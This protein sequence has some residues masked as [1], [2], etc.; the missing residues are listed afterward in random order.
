MKIKSIKKIRLD[1]PKQ[2]YDISVA[3][4][5]NFV[6]SDSKVVVHNSSVSGAICTMT[7]HFAGANNYPYFTGDGAFG[8]RIQGPGNGNGSPRYVSVKLSDITNEVVFKDKELV[9]MIPSYDEEDVEPL[10]YL[11]LVPTVLM[12]PSKGIAVGYACTFSPFDMK[13]IISNQIKV[14]QGERQVKLKPFYKGYKGKVDVIDDVFYSTG[15]WEFE[16]KTVLKISELPIGIT[17][18]AYITLLEDLIDKDVVVRYEDNCTESFD[19]TVK[20]RNNH[21]YAEDEENLVKTF[22]LRDKIQLNTTVIGI[23]GTI[24][25]KSVYEIIEEFTNWRLTYYE[26]RYQR[27]LKKTVTEL[28]YKHSLLKVIEAGIMDSVRKKPRSVIMQEILDL[29]IRKEFATKIVSLPIYRFSKN[30]VEKLEEEVKE[31]MRKRKILKK[32]IQSPDKLR[33]TYVKELNRA[34]ELF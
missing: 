16:C 20:L 13:R 28:R 2:L 10:H 21:P 25:N 33:E 17:R 31:L 32:L 26:K 5:H 19:I 3:D 12:N 7:Q 29:E 4:Y 27:I 1:A 30:E 14:L 15:C 8:S 6:V 34:K 9:E 11:P 24:A 22:K 18:D 23:D